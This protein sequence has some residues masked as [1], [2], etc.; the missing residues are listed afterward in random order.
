[1]EKAGRIAA[2]VT[3]WRGSAGMAEEV[4]RA[5]RHPFYLQEGEQAEK[6]W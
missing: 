5:G 3:G 1:M 6:G 4:Q 2:T